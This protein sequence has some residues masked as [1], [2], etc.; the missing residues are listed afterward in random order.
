M[1]LSPEDTRTAAVF[2]YRSRA[3]ANFGSLRLESTP[4]LS[5]VWERL[6]PLAELQTRLHIR[7]FS[8]PQQRPALQS[9]TR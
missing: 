1:K 5:T 6:E 3:T 8:S 4:R 7:F 2:D 9:T